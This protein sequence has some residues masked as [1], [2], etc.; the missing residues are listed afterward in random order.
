MRSELSR[1]LQMT[2]I[3][4]GTK[5][6]QCGVEVHHFRQRLS[7]STSNCDD[8]VND[9][10][11]LVMETEKGSEGLDCDSEMTKACRRGRHWVG[12]DVE[13]SSVL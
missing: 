5:M 7:S 6:L 1:R 12:L 4:C 2:I 8:S 9:D 11:L 10:S 13:G 3:V